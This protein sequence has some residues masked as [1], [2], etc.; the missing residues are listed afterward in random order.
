MKHGVDSCDI[1]QAVLA[2]PQE[3]RVFVQ[4]DANAF[5]GPYLLQSAALVT[6]HLRNY[7]AAT[8][9]DALKQTARINP[10]SR[11][12]NIFNCFVQDVANR[13]PSTATVA[14]IVAFEFRGEN[15]VKTVK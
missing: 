7:P 8:I 2:E 6:A 12:T 3:K 15:Q 9:E 14:V 11:G 5:W 10:L 4:V 13:L 1:L